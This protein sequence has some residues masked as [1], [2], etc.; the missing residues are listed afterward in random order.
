A[1]P[2]AT[3]GSPCLLPFA[4]A[5]SR[6]FIASTSLARCSGS[7]FANFISVSGGASGHRSFGVRRLSITSTSFAAASTSTSAVSTLLWPNYSPFHALRA[8][9]PTYTAA[10]VPMPCIH[11][12]NHVCQNSGFSQNALHGT[13]GFAHAMMATTTINAATNGPI[14]TSLYVCLPPAH[15]LP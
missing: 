9:H 13:S 10:A 7:T 11:V 4:P 15:T 1:V 3:L 12:G 8:C 6:L 5:A 2:V 14:Q